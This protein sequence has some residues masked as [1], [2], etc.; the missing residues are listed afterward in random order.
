[1]TNYT[2]TE[3]VFPNDYTNLIKAPDIPYPTVFSLSAGASE[4]TKV[5]LKESQIPPTSWH[6]CLLLHVACQQDGVVPSS[7]SIWH[8]NNLAQK[9]LVIEYV[10]PSKK[11]TL[12]ILLK[13]I[14]AK[15]AHFEIKRIKGLK[16]LKVQLQFKDKGLDKRLIPKITHIN[17]KAIDNI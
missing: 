1:M 3:F 16:N 9:N 6:P 11:V 14:N 12:P 10:G 17:D 7:S 4:V 8:P 2:G 5:R 13:N 15:Q